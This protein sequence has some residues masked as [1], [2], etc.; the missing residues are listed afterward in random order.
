MTCFIEI[1]LFKADLRDY[2]KRVK[3]SKNLLKNETESLY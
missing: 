2:I 3:N 1:P